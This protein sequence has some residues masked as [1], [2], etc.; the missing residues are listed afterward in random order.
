MKKTT[1]VFGLVSSFLLIIGVI[2]KANHWAGAGIVFFIS[3]V[4]FALGYSPLLFTDR[5]KH[6]RSGEQ[7]VVNLAS[8]ITMLIVSAAFLFK[9]MHWPGAGK[10]VVTGNLIL[11]LFIPVLLIRASKEKDPVRRLNFF[12]ESII[13]IVLT[14]ASLYLWLGRMN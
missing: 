9:L 3:V 7:K 6:A 14:A 4:L 12:N 2:M 1:L 8:M 10:L 11:V 13:V 5:N